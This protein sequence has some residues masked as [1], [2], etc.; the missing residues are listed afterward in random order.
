[1]QPRHCVGN[2]GQA[3]TFSHAFHGATNSVHV[4]TKIEKPSNDFDVGC[5]WSATTTDS[6]NH[7]HISDSATS[8][9]TAANGVPLKSP[10]TPIVPE[11]PPEASSVPVPWGLFAG[12]SPVETLPLP[13]RSTAIPEQQLVLQSAAEEK[14]MLCNSLEAN[15]IEDCWL[16][17]Q[18][19]QMP[20]PS[21]VPSQATR[22]CKATKVAKVDQAAVNDAIENARFAQARALAMRARREKHDQQSKARGTSNQHTVQGRGFIEG[23]KCTPKRRLEEPR[24]L[25]AKLL[26]EL[27]KS[28]MAKTHGSDTS[29]ESTEV[30]VL[31]ARAE[32]LK[33]LCRVQECNA[34]SNRSWRSRSAK[35]ISGAKNAEAC[36]GEA[37]ALITT[38]IATQKCSKIRRS[39]SLRA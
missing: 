11:E 29:P 16:Q 35:H 39:R 13:K 31:T 9:G 12:P 15:A 33:S 8:S 37:G 22:A 30:E 7:G 23:S 18:M 6:E 17:M 20:A 21:Q 24:Q 3:V 4:A 36:A 5:T 10:V 2:L 14:D 28:D 34:A 25:L 38:S 32:A 27:E 26:N 1:M 19:C